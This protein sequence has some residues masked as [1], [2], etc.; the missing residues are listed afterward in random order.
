M[1][2]WG[3]L[4]VDEMAMIGNCY[5]RIPPPAPNTKR[6]RSIHLSVCSPLMTAVSK[7]TYHKKLYLFIF[8]CK[9]NRWDFSKLYLVLPYLP[10]KLGLMVITRP[11]QSVS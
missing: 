11:G 3:T 1:V 5:N 6:E 4:N 7:I 8:V 10:T 2:I 9:K